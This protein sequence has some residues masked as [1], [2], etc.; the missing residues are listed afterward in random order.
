VR[1]FNRLRGAAPKLTTP[2]DR[3]LTEEELRLADHLLRH[4]APPEALAF[5]PQLAHARV[6]GYCP[7]GCPTVDL[8][9]PP[10]MRVQNPPP[11]RPLADATGRVNEKLV[12][13]MLFQENGLLSLLEGYRLEDVSDDPFRLPAVETVERLQ[14][15][16][17]GS[18]RSTQS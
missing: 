16:E 7:C 18:M 9:V 11:E 1:L 3:P 12:G 6:T 4:A 10:E 17:D 14:W 15:N 5:I 2:V 13:V 8:S